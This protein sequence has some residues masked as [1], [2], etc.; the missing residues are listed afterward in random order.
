[1]PIIF[2]IIIWIFVFLIGISTI[3]SIFAFVKISNIRKQNELHIKKSDEFFNE[4]DIIRG[5]LEKIEKTLKEV[6]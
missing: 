6:D 5:K 1:M 2:V 4:L 3:L